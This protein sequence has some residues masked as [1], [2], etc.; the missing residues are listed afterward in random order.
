[1]TASRFKE[2]NLSRLNDKPYH[3]LHTRTTHKDTHSRSVVKLPQPFLRLDHHPWRSELT[4]YSSS[5]LYTESKSVSLLIND[6]YPAHWLNCGHPDHR[7]PPTSLYSSITSLEAHHS[8]YAVENAFQLQVGRQNATGSAS[9]R[10]L[11]ANAKRPV[12][13]HRAP[14]T[15]FDH[16]TLASA[17]CYA[18]T[19]LRC[20]PLPIRFCWG[21][22]NRAAWHAWRW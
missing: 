16:L 5:Q 8:A 2:N 6:L 20:T 7:R 4:I 9:P 10:R 17:S 21:G 15:G 12:S 18:S 14:R 3:R 22:P 1:V 19:S 11:R 13:R